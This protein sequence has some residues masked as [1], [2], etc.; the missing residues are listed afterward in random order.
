MGGELVVNCRSRWVIELKKWRR[1]KISFFKPKKERLLCQAPSQSSILLFVI[2]VMYITLYYI[3]KCTDS[4]T[5]SSKCYSVNIPSF[6]CM[7]SMSNWWIG[8]FSGTFGFAITLLCLFL[9]MLLIR[10]YA[11]LYL[12]F[13]VCLVLI[14]GRLDC[15]CGFCVVAIIWVGF[16]VFF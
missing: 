3:Y 14:I 11:W 8:L 5:F 16:T 12:Y 13:L 10:D 6:S 7:F 15:F 4:F 1:W 9:R 2:F